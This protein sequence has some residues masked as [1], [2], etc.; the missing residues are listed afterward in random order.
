MS[1]L[2]DKWKTEMAKLQQK[3][4]A[5]FS[6]ESGESLPSNA[7]CSQGAR[8]KEGNSNGLASAFGRV[9]RVNY[10]D[11]SVFMIVECFSP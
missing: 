9:M 8:T 6:S 11:A 3:G 10:S 2:V 7:G 1:K 5:L 4:Q